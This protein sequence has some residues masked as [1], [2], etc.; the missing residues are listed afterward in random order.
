ME[1]SQIEY[2][3]KYIQTGANYFVHKNQKEQ[4]LKLVHS[5]DQWNIEKYVEGVKNDDY[6]FYDKYPGCKEVVVL[7]SSNS[8]K[9]TLINALNMGSEAAYTAKR[10]GKTQALNFYLAQHSVN[11]RKQGFI[12]DSPGYGYVFAPVNIKKKWQKMV[13]KYLGYGVRLNLIILCINGH[14]GLKQNDLSM[15]E[16]LQHFRKPVQ[17]VLTKVDK[18]T[19]GQGE[20]VRVTTETS[21]HIQKY[22][23][24]G[25]VNPEIHLTCAEHF[26]GVKELRARIGVAFEESD[27]RANRIPR[28]R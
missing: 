27:V 2:L 8:G 7:G 28:I 19:G 24:K 14:I 5:I 26:F 9:S 6:D 25:F 12:V 15:L 16:D 11:K 4:G 23:A 22:V 1:S 3:P 13:Y 20:L 10:P 18:I 21:R 17:V